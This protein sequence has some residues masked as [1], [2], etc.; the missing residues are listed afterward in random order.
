MCVA[1]SAASNRFELFIG[2]S[3]SN[4]V[5]AQSLT[6]SGSKVASR[7]SI[8]VANAW[9]HSAGVF[10]D[11]SYYFVQVN[12]QTSYNISGTAIPTSIDASYVGAVSTAGVLSRY[13]NGL[14]AEVAIWSAALTE[15]ECAALWRRRSP[16]TIRPQS[17]V[18]YYPLGGFWG[19]TDLDVWKSGLDLTATNSPTWDNHPPLFYRPQYGVVETTYVEPPTFLAAWAAN[20]NARLIGGG[21]R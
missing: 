7:S 19:Q 6:P 15:T 12:G 21:V 16:L 14:I 2:R 5:A 10:R 3:S 9:N 8:A 20:R 4:Q 1:D 13:F 18:A 11:D 17:L